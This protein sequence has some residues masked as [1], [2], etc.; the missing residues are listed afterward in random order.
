MSLSTLVF[1]LFTPN[2]RKY[3][4]VPWAGFLLSMVLILGSTSKTSL[5]IILTIVVLSFLYR[6]LR[7]KYSVV[8]PFLIALI[9]VGGSVATLLVSNAEAILGLFGRDLTLTGRT[10]L[11]AAVLDKISERPWLGYGFGAFWR[12]LEGQSADVW[13]IVRW[14]VPHSHNGYLD[15]W[16]DLGLLGFSTFV[17]SFILVFS[18]SVNFLRQSKTKE[19][20]L[21]LIFLTFLLMANLTE[22]SFFREEFLWSLYV[23]VSLLTH[24]PSDNITKINHVFGQKKVQAGVTK[25]ITSGIQEGRA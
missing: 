18:R 11:W 16:L 19:G 1:L 21:P 13:N 15:I 17:F 8:I 14:E 25:E 2:S 3:C 6:S 24:Q 10:E 22:S 20:L 7:W 4:W 12:G 23:A 9:L 5:V